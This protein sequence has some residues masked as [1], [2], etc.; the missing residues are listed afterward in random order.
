MGINKSYCNVLL[1]VTPAYFH[2]PMVFLPGFPNDRVLERCPL[3]RE[4]CK[5]NFLWASIK[6]LA[7][8]REHSCPPGLPRPV[9]SLC[10]P[11][12]GDGGQYGTPNTIPFPL[13][14]LPFPSH[15]LSSP[16]RSNALSEHTS[17]YDCPWSV[18]VQ[19]HLVTVGRWGWMASCL[20]FATT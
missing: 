8:G 13:Y 16:P 6:V 2:W 20:T 11:T 12:S 4:D 1:T 9:S 14:L 17:I 7:R 10:W 19:A 5:R 3:T 15:L 18:D